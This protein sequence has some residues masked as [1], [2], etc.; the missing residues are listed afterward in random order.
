MFRSRGL[1][2]LEGQGGGS[3]VIP[4]GWPAAA[5]NRGSGGWEPRGPPGEKDT[6]SLAALGTSWGCVLGPREGEP[7]ALGNQGEAYTCL[8]GTP[9]KGRYPRLV[10]AHWA[11]TRE[12]RAAGGRSRVKMQRCKDAQLLSWLPGDADHQWGRRWHGSRTRRRSLRTEANVGMAA[13]AA[14]RRDKS[15]DVSLNRPM[16][17]L[18]QRRE[19]LGS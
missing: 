13:C 2:A 1:A 19:G 16:P 4:G 10:S 11:R 12:G 5:G 15:S 3:E 9:E 8:Q 18:T 17:F 7:E 14:C 6:W